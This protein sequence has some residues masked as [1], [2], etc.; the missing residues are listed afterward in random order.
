V[1]AVPRR[2]RVQ[3]EGCFFLSALT[4]SAQLLSDIFRPR[5]VRVRALVVRVQVSYGLAS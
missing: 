1:F 3:R 2:A 4:E 5:D